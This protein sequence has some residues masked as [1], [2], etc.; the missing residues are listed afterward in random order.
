MH[1]FIRNIPPIERRQIREKANGIVLGICALT[2]GDHG[3]LAT[4][5]YDLFRVQNGKKLLN[6]GIPQNT[7][8]QIPPAAE[9]KNSNGKF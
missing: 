2:R 6:T 9:W 4:S 1:E 8:E 3:G 7:T 5:Y